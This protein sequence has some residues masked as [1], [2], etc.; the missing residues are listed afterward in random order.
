M[1]ERIGHPLLRQATRRLALVLA[2][3]GAGLA[4]FAAWFYGRDA[5]AAAKQ[6]IAAVEGLLRERVARQE[7]TWEKEASG[8][9]TELELLRLP[10]R[11]DRLP[12]LTELLT[13]VASR[14]TFSRVAIFG[15][16]GRLI[17]KYGHAGEDLLADCP[18]AYR[19][20]WCLHRSDGG[21][22]RVV[23]RSLSLGYGPDANGEIALFYPADNGL[24]ARNAFVDTHLFLVWRGR[25]V[26]SSLGDTALTDVQP[27]RHGTILRDGIRYD[28]QT[29][30]FG[31]APGDKPQLI[32]QHRVAGLVSARDLGSGV[33]LLTLA[34]GTMVWIVL[35]HWIVVATRRISRL[36]LAATAFR[37]S[38]QLTPQI[39]AALR[40]GAGARED[41]IADLAESLDFLAHEVIRRMTAQDAGE[42]AVRES[43]RRLREITDVL[44]DGVYVVDAEGKVNFINPEGAR[45][46][47][48][49]QDELLGRDAH[50]TFHSLNPDGSLLPIEQCPIHRNDALRPP[51]RG[52]DLLLIR[53][54]STFFP[55][56]LAS[57]PLIRDGEVVGAVTAFHDITGLKRA[58]AAI[59]DSERRFRALFNGGMDAIYVLPLATPGGPPPRIVEVNDVACK[60]LGRGHDELLGMHLQDIDAP[61]Q[62]D[63]GDWMARLLR[64]GHLLFERVHLTRDGRRVPV[65][66]S[67]SLFPLR[68]QVMVIAVARDVGER[69]RAEIEY[70]QII[71]T[72]IDGYWLCEAGS[73]RILD[74]ND[75]FCEMLGFAREELLQ[76]HI[77]EIEAGDATEPRHQS[78]AEIAAAGPCR[79]ET[80][81]RRKDGRLIDVEVSCRDSESRGGVVFVF[82]RDITE[83]KLDEARIRQLAFFDPLTGL[84][85]RRLLSDRLD[86]ALALA[87]RY[88]RLAAVLF[89]D[90]DRFKDIND[91]YGHSVGDEVLKIVAQR[92]SACVRYSDTVSRQGGDEFV[93]LLPEVANAANAEMLAQK[94]LDVLAKPVVLGENRLS[95]TPSVGIALYPDDGEDGEAL[96]TRADKAMYAAKTAGRNCY[97]RY[98]APR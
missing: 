24:L 57:N 8:L 47:G 39:E 37:D 60:M 20:N 2:L 48:W 9:R 15:A 22:S 29:I 46:L 72:A 64:E 96:V 31:E 44:A 59:R 67:A 13:A 18:D 50:A 51:Y 54:D 58:E 81:H 53:R 97:R 27:G 3:A 25:L 28:Q 90:L 79:F 86:Q 19:T 30:P 11:T 45:L 83:R 69:K 42:K 21:L 85:N 82:V 71:Q 61:G 88:Q 68:G 49:R 92:L 89:V 40:Q 26:A 63:G 78:L 32:F 38:Y 52:D 14:S 66:I 76:K 56:S 4:G 87:S 35:G 10:D 7:A 62:D 5:D 65:E 73:G 41:E 6:E 33:V 94:I 80:R 43:D 75:A 12:R 93:V 74:V 91:A 70:R 36:K 34:I 77:G 16:D 95:A 1:A 17:Y 84:P 98:Q 23:H 55:V